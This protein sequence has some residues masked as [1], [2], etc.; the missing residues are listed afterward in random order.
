MWLHTLGPNDMIHFDPCKWEIKMQLIWN[1]SWQWRKIYVHMIGYNRT[2]NLTWSPSGSVWT[3]GP[4]QSESE[5]ARQPSWTDPLSI[6]RTLW[7]T[8]HLPSWFDSLL[9]MGLQSC[10]TFVQRD[11]F[12]YCTACFHSSSYYRKWPHTIAYMPAIIKLYPQQWPG[13]HWKEKNHC[14]HEL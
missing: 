9:S 8:L 7:W 10:S 1:I 6:L 13:W 4:Q 2:Q 11:L 3:I 14:D 12:C 5:I